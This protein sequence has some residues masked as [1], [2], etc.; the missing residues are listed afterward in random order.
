MHRCHHCTSTLKE[1]MEREDGIVVRGNSE[2][3]HVPCTLH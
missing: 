3:M 2:G 1:R